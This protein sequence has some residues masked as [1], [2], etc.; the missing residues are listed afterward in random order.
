MFEKWITFNKVIYPSL[1]KNPTKLQIFESN[2]EPFI[3]CMHIRKLN[4]CGWVSI[5]KYEEYDDDVSYC[6]VNIKTHWTNLNPH[7]NDSIQK[8]IIA[9]FDIECMSESGN[10]PQATNDS[11]PIIQIGTVFSYYGDSEPF[12]KNI[13]T[14]GGCSKIK[15]LEDVDIE[16]LKDERRVLLAWTKLIQKYNPDIITGYNI[17]G[18]DFEYMKNR[19]K[20]LGILSSFEELSKVKGEIAEFKEKNY[21][22]LH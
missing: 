15:G 22:L 7:L 2:I 14:L 11:D 10:F 18:F 16:A 8:F 13:I 12:Y 1:F 4:A 19:A 20:K 21:H 6:D 9:S 17:N 5:N 3:R